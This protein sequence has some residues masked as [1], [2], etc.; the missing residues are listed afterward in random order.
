MTCPK[1]WV[2][3]NAKPS[4]NRERESDGSVKPRKQSDGDVKPSRPSNGSARI[5]L[6]PRG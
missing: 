6:L 3:Y 2:P 5:Y 4:W 1:Y